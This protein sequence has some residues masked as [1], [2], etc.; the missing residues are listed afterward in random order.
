[1]GK[2]DLKRDNA[3]ALRFQRSNSVGQDFANPGID[4][5]T[6]QPWRE[7]DP[8]AVDRS[9][10]RT[11][12]V[13]IGGDTEGILALISRTT[14]ISTRPQPACAKPAPTETRFLAANSL[15]SG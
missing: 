3:R 1:M 2:F 14:R 11:R 6:A 9:G 5:K 13:D 7:A 10:E 8:A 12:P 4:G 15:K